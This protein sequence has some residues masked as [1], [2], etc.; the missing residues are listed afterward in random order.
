MAGN[1]PAVLT[2]APRVSGVLVLR[3]GTGAGAPSAWVGAVTGASASAF[4]AFALL[5]RRFVGFFSIFD[6]DFS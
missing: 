5:V 6:F 2:M 4:G 3:A 1:E